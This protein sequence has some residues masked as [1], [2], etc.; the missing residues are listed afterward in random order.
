MS[1][2]SSPTGFDAPPPF[3]GAEPA[4]P[5]HSFFSGPNGLRAGWRLLI[6]FA[7][8]VPLS[9]GI[10]SALTHFPPL[11]AWVRAQKGGMTPGL[12]I[13]SEGTVFLALMLTAFL[14]TRI[15][16]RSFADYGLPLDQTFGK[17]FWQGMPV[18]FAML[19]ILMALIAAA[20]DFSLGH[21]ALS[22]AGTFH[23]GLLYMLAF[24][25]VGLFEEFSFRGYLQATLASGIGF[26]PAAVVLAVAFGGIHLRNS[27]EAAFGALAAGCFGLVAA[28]SLRRTGNLWFAIGM[29]AAWDWGETFFYS[30]PDSGI[31]AQGHLLNS[32]FHGSRWVSGGSIGPEGSIFVLLV[33]GL[34]AV[35]IHYMFPPTAK[36][37]DT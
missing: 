6:A 35:V 2:T 11:R 13:F 15:E 17:R 37:S 22:A 21:L 23:Y 28:L 20:H 9:A 24:I 27:G 1:S 7:I 29:H 14:M 26:W 25:L 30:V 3:G 34:W 36:P 33:L 19:S 5:A 10:G 16:H 31:T 32:S 18:G 12:A 4:Q 8:F